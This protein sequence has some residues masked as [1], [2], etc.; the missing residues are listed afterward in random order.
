MIEQQADGPCMAA[1]GSPVQ[2]G[3]P[4]GPELRADVD[5]FFQQV[6]DDI[7]AAVLAGP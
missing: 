5:P 3:L 6:R 2:A 7:G 4:V 1:V